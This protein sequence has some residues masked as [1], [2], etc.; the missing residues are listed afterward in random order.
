MSGEFIAFFVLAICI[1]AGA[2]FMLFMNNVVHMVFSI[3]FTFLSIAGIY[4]LLQAEFVAVVQVI[5]YTG[6]ISILAVFGIMLTR[7]DGK[8]EEKKRSGHTIFALLVVVAFIGLIIWSVQG[9]PWGDHAADYDQMQNTKEIGKALFTQYV[10]PFELTS[11]LLL[12]A[13]VG[14]IILAKEEDKSE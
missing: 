9:A 4:V 2:V 10:I 1:F 14:S 6:A 8:E 7:H 11:V 13:L 12:V 3:A 5:V